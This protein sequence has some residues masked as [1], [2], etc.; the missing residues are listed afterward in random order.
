MEPQELQRLPDDL[1]VPEDDGAARHLP[2][3]QMPDITLPRS[4]GGEARLSALGSG[5]TVI[6]LY[7]RTGRP[8]AGCPPSPSK[9]SR[10]TSG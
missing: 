10:C 3:Q 6:Y 4:D 2:G 8:G 9:G 5:T 1:P 7:P